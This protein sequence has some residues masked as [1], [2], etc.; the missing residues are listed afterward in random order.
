MQTVQDEVNRMKKELKEAKQE[1]TAIKQQI[2]RGGGAI[3]TDVAVS[4][5]SSG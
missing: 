1:T 3:P 4:L 2:K 5:R